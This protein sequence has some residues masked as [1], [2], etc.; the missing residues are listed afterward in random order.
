M[1]RQSTCLTRRM[2]Y[3][4]RDSENCTLMTGGVKLEM[5][6]HIQLQTC[7]ILSNLNTSHVEQI[8][9]R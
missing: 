1:T 4:I 3:T 8:G 2:L 6:R 9:P 7:K 5:T